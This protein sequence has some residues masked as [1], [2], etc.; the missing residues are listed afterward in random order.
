MEE[1]RG[2]WIKLLHV[3]YFFLKSSQE[4]RQDLLPFGVCLT[5]YF[6]KIWSLKYK[7]LQLHLLCYAVWNLIPF[8]KGRTQAEG[9]EEQC[10]KEDTWA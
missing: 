5:S 4:L 8:L 7:E 9:V 2:D 1:V 10:A 6:P 3:L